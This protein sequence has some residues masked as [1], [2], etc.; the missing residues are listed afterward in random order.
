MRNVQMWFMLKGAS[1][2]VL[3]F[4]WTKVELVSSDVCTVT[5]LHIRE[6]SFNPL[7]AKDEFD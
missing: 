2:F 3:D 6:L 1:V 7:A 5:L 4:H